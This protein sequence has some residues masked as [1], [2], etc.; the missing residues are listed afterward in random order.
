VNREAFVPKESRNLV[1]LGSLPP[2]KVIS[3]TF[4]PQELNAR[5]MEE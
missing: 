5:A 1:S 4:V 3:V 2:K